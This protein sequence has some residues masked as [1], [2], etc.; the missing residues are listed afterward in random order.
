VIVSVEHGKNGSGASGVYADEQLVQCVHVG[1]MPPRGACGGVGED[2]AVQAVCSRIGENFLQPGKLCG[3]EGMGMCI[4]A[5]CAASAVGIVNPQ[6]CGF[7]EGISG[8]Q[9]D[10]AEGTAVEEEV[11]GIVRAP[12]NLAVG[13]VPADGGE[14][15]AAAFQIVIAEHTVYIQP[16][17][18][19]EPCAD[20]LRRAGVIVGEIAAVND[21]IGSLR[22]SARKDILKMR[23]SGGVGI[24]FIMQVGKESE[25]ECIHK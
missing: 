23:D 18:I 10:D 4:S 16:V 6:L 11:S 22:G 21:K 9:T 8:I 19:F 2:E 12:C 20:Q 7:T 13:E 15:I 25:G 14:G 1:I 24:L 17:G 5:R 3:A